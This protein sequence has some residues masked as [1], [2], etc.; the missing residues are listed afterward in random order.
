MSYVHRFENVFVDIG[1]K[2][3]LHTY[4]WFFSY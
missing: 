3:I 2:F 4:S 1:H